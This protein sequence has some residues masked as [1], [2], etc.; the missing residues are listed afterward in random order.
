MF[1]DLLAA[2]AAFGIGMFLFSMIFGNQE[3]GR[4]ATGKE[5][6]PSVVDA[7]AKEKEKEKECWHGEFDNA[8]E[9]CR[10]AAGWDT[11]HI[12]DTVDFLEDVC[13][14]FR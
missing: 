3:V 14:Q 1:A 8:D 6:S 13:E 12:T 4:A 10:C 2:L 7:T 11:A 5:N 9:V